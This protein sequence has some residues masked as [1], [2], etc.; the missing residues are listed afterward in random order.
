MIAPI[1]LVSLVSLA[2]ASSDSSTV[3]SIEPATS[4]VVPRSKE[5]KADSAWNR[6]AWSIEAGYRSG[7][8]WGD[9][10]DGEADMADAVDL[11]VTSMGQTSRPVVLLQ[12]YALGFGVWHGIGRRFELGMGYDHTWTLVNVGQ[13]G[14]DL[15]L[16]ARSLS[17]RARFWAFRRLQWQ[18]GPKLG[19]GPM[20]GTLT[21]YS[22]EKAASLSGTT[23][24]IAVARAILDAGNEELSVTGL[25]VE[26]GA[27]M[28]LRILPA[29]S[30][31]GAIQLIRQAMSISDSDP[32]YSTLQMAGI[33]YPMDPVQWSAGLELHAAYRF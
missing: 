27:A 33:P 9:L 22:I 3:G 30:I 15:L 14:F 29:F 7:F 25:R 24:D 28:E 1:L 23:N 2:S 31:G 19:V 12:D 4:A 21:R 5:W 26:G 16:S 10:R 18:I 8:A 32:L 20:W 6:E 11:K 17:A 13:P